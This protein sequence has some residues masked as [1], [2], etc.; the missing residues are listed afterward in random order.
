MPEK[1]PD[2]QHSAQDWYLISEGVF[3]CDECDEARKQ[4]ASPEQPEEIRKIPDMTAD[5]MKK[6]ILGVCDRQ[7]FTDRHTRHDDEVGMVFMIV[8]L[9]GLKD[10]DVN[11]LGCIWEWMSQAGPMSCN[12]MPMFFSCRLMNKKDAAFAFVQIEK[13]MK[14]REALTLQMD[15]NLDE[16][17]KGRED[18][19]SQP[20]PDQAVSDPQQ[21]E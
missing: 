1:A 8:A 21:E 2:C 11:D 7:I 15:L 14:R 9:G 13:E 12:G 19:T 5:Q 4:A 3:G 10:V 20:G 17:M 16:A 18:G 6:F